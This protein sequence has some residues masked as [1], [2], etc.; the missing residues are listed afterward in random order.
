M[1]SCKGMVPDRLNVPTLYYSITLVHLHGI[2]D[3]MYCQVPLCADHGLGLP[4]KPLLYKTSDTNN[5]DLEK[6]YQCHTSA[7]H[8]QTEKSTEVVC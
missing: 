7:K 8:Q 1:A 6:C 4:W 5:N 2:K 3:V